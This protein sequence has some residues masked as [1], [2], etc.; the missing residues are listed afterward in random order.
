VKNQTT[1]IFITFLGHNLDLE[2]DLAQFV[3]SELDGTIWKK[4]MWKCNMD[5]IAWSREEIIS[6]LT[7]LVRENN[8]G[9]RLTYYK[10]NF[11]LMKPHRIDVTII[12]SEGIPHPEIKKEIFKK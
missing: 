7:N 4:N 10:P 12:K 1:D 2:K 6:E 5:N 8:G 9:I 11:F 3:E